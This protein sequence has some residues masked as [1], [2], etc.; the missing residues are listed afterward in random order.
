MSKYEILKEYEQ[1][2]MLIEDILG[3]GV[4]T[5]VQLDKLCYYLFNNYL[6]TFSSE[7]FPKHILKSQCFIINNKSSKSKGEHWI[8][9]FMKDK[10]YVY[11]SFNRNVHK[12][13]H[14]FKNLHFI[15]SNTDRDE[16]YKED[17]CGQR[18]VSWLISASIYGPE[19]IMNII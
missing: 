19:K 6:G 12:L 2:L 3:P 7:K 8:A 4:T 16:S 10:L 13:S 18:C 14:H 5:N 1:N 11:D 15:N 17:N 9:V